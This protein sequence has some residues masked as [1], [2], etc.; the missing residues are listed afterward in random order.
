MAEHHERMHELHKSHADA[1]DDVEGRDAGA[2]LTPQLRKLIGI[3]ELSFVV[4]RA[5]FFVPL[6]LY[7]KRPAREKRSQVQRRPSIGLCGPFESGSLGL[8]ARS[9][10]NHRAGELRF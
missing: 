1:L 7:G 5:R 9:S 3:E 4:V 2:S 8:P 6:L 10:V